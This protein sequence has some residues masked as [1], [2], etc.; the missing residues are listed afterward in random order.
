MIRHLRENWRVIYEVAALQTS[1]AQA[2]VML[3]DT[4]YEEWACRA[5]NKGL[6]SG[7]QQSGQEDLRAGRRDALLRRARCKSLWRTP[8]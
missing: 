8:Q 4:T 2:M 3:V 1:E 7:L 5:R 6:Q